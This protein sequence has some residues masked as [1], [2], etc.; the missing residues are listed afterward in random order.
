MNGFWYLE[1]MKIRTVMDDNL[2]KLAEIAK[3][4]GIIQYMYNNPVE[5]MNLA[6]TTVEAKNKKSHGSKGVKGS[7]GAK[8]GGSKGGKQGS[9][10]SKG[11]KSG[12]S[13]GGKQGSKG[14]K[15]NKRQGSKG[16]KH[17]GEDKK[18]K[19]EDFTEDRQ[20]SKGLDG[21]KSIAS[22]ITDIEEIRRLEEIIKKQIRELFHNN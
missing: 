13:K 1:G 10:G 21:N 8:S 4:N 6:G 15:G 9:K 16:D 18:D 3:E 14:S 7:K 12:G 2:R 17:H 11:A 20:I 22:P 19:R 5:D